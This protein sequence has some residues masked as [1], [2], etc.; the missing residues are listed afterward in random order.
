MINIEAYYK[1]YISIFAFIYIIIS[2]FR[3]YADFTPDE[4]MNIE[5][6]FLYICP[7][8]QCEAT[9]GEV[10]LFKAPIAAIGIVLA[11]QY[12]ALAFI[13]SMG[14][15]METPLWHCYCRPHVFKDSY[16]ILIEP[17][18]DQYDWILNYVKVTL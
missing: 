1:V 12:A 16:R 6:R 4:K 13:A 18:P 9:T 2:P 11:K 7:S 17:E 14:F 8:S 15:G 3:V 5:N 10:I